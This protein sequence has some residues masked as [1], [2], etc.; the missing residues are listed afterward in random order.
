MACSHAREGTPAA[1]VHSQAMTAC[2]SNWTG[3]ASAS[4]PAVTAAYAARPRRVL[5]RTPPAS[6]TAGAPYSSTLSRPGR[7]GASRSG[8]TSRSAGKPDAAA[9][10]RRPHHD[11][12]GHGGSCHQ[13]NTHAGEHPVCLA[14]AVE[15]RDEPDHGACRRRGGCPGRCRKQAG[16]TPP[17]PRK[18]RERRHHRRFSHRFTV[19][20]TAR[21][22]TKTHN[23]IIG[24]PHRVPGSRP[25]SRAESA[26]SSLR[27]GG[28]C[29]SA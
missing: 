13:H 25:D 23:R 11:R 1:C 3:M 24:A 28:P 15:H 20:L 5:A 22:G 26:I 18:S 29:R 6:S 8:S 2:C 9:P 14:T 17:A 12:Q 4:T 7:N 27:P 19:G 10:R 16:L 21:P